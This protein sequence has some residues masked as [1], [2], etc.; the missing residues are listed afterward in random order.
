LHSHT[1]EALVIVT[2][3]C[4]RSVI[5]AERAENRM[6]RSGAW[7]RRGRK[8]WSGSGVRGRGAGSGGYRNRLERRA[9][10]LPLA[11][12]SHAPIVIRDQ[13]MRACNRTYRTGFMIQLELLLVFVLCAGDRV[14][15]RFLDD[16][17]R[18][19]HSFLGFARPASKTVLQG[20]PS[21]TKG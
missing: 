15:S 1:R 17:H 8:R 6:Q 2:R 21:P 3:A 20:A 19:E 12:R 14:I 16:D 11:L 10:F 5:G 18:F 9:A 4:E 13:Y 7:S